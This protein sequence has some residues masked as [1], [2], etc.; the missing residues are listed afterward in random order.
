MREQL[1][2]AYETTDI[3]SRISDKFHLS[4]LNGPRLTILGS[5]KKEYTVKFT[6]LATG[7]LVYETKIKP[8]HWSEARPKWNITWHVEIFYKNKL[9]HEYTFDLKGKK[10]A[11]GFGSKSIGDTLAWIPYIEQFQEH[12][13]CEVYCATWHNDWNSNNYDRISKILKSHVT[14]SD[15]MTVYFCWSREDI[16]E[17]TWGIF[18]KYWINFLFDDEGPILI[19]KEKSEVFTFLPTGVVYMG[20]RK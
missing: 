7:V 1:L 3:D 15:D 9:V 18:N 6:N 16:F 5:S 8:G 12:Y 13:K 19:A 10:V 20:D 14:W 17:T 11:V 2:K 4:F